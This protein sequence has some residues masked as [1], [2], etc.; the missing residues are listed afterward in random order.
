[1]ECTTRAQQDRLLA[2]KNL[3][4]NIKCHTLV[5]KTEGV[6]Y[7]LKDKEL[8][9]LIKHPNVMKAAPIKTESK[10]NH[11]SYQFFPK[12]SKLV[13]EEWLVVF[14][15]CCQGCQ[16]LNHSK[17]CRCGQTSHT[18]RS[19]NQDPLCIN[20]GGKHCSISWL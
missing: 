12:R 3:A 18:R 16:G 10:N 6:I 14:P 5:I 13:R 9:L 15:Y 11:S 4:G 2:L 7:G 8:D 19:C 1:M 17:R 20:C